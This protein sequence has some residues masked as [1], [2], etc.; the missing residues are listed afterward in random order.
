MEVIYIL[1]PFD[2]AKPLPKTRCAGALVEW[3]SK[4]YAELFVDI[5]PALKYVVFGSQGRWN[6]AYRIQWYPNEMRARRRKT[7]WVA[8]AQSV[9][10][11]R[12]YVKPESKFRLWDVEESKLDVLPAFRRDLPP[13]PY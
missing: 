12:D 3:L 13:E 5:R 1:P 4:S 9:D 8:S 2:R 6:D 7:K 11:A 10:I